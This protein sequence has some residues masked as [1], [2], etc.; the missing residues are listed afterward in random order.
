VASDIA[1]TKNGIEL[2]HL[3]YYVA[4]VE[5]LHFGHAAERLHVAQPAVSQAI[6]KLESELGLQLLHRTSR[7][8]TVT[9]PGRVFAV[10]ARA[11]LA[12]VDRAVEATLRA[13]GDAAALRVG[14][15]PQLPMER[16]QRFLT[17]LK[18]RDPSVEASVTHG[19]PDDQVASL[20]NMELDIGIFRDDQPEGIE[21]EPLFAGEP[22]MAY[23]PTGHRLAAKTVL[24]PADLAN[25]R[26]IGMQSQ[27]ACDQCA[28]LR[29]QMEDWGYSFE[30][31][32]EPA[33]L[34]PRDLMLS[35]ARGDGV[36]LGPRSLAETTSATAVVVRRPMEPALALPDVV[37]A[38]R[39][40]PPAHLRPILSTVR[41]VARE[42]RESAAD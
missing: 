7:V 13:G 35:V 15:V 1:A 42:I 18:G 3:R 33:S 29:V 37:V 17:V 21:T 20:V 12:R 25:E 27:N 16:L 5:D 9:E 22:L 36:L 32:H 34:D 2:R 10:E 41:H 6:R 31:M 28:R 38:W 26:L 14:C 11:A 23:L 30:S 24:G 19:S 4:V 8:V 40:D 39:A